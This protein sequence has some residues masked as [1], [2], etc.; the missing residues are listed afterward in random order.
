MSWETTIAESRYHTQDESYY[1]GAAT[2][3]IIL[4]EIGVSYSSLDQDDL[5]N[6]N[7]THNSHSSSSGWYTDAEGL[8]YTLNNRR[9]E[10]FYP[11]QF[12][13]S[14]DTTEDNAVRALVWALVDYKVS[15]GALVF[16]G[17]HWNVVCGVRTGQDPY[18]G[19]YTIEGFYHQ[20]P[21]YFSPP[22]PPP[23]NATDAC[24]SGGP[25]GITT[26]FTTYDA[27]LADWFTGFNYDDPNG[28]KQWISV[29]GSTKVNIQLPKKPLS[30]SPL[31]GKELITPEQATKAASSGMAEHKLAESGPLSSVLK[32]GSLGDPV[33]VHRLDRPGQY[34]YLSPWEQDS[35]IG[36]FAEVDARF[37]NFKGF[38]AFPSP[39]KE[40]LIGSE[41]RNRLQ[42]E[43][44]TR[45]DGLRIE[46][47]QGNGF[48]V[49]KPGTYGQL[50]VL[51]WRPC[52]ESWSP[53]LP[54]YMVTTGT[55]T[56]YVRIDGKVFTDL[57]TSARGG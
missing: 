28:N 19:N 9:P 31:Q 5:Y 37:G 48:V 12:A 27:W 41:A 49:V 13:V 6:S 23:H 54:F 10:S 4:A 20:N 30:S 26:E 45:V 24:G 46:R 42:S 57:A 38:R 17:A 34:Y 16:D 40:L 1:C 44:A 25:H 29:D 55:H 22:P 47:P 18:G 11:K 33:V 36:G 7:H 43:I 8:C 39:I 3:M 21:V 32:K 51:V 50:P 56:V 2:A 14:K 52:R 53:S 35:G 15:P